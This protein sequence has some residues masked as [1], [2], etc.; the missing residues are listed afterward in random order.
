MPTIRIPKLLS[1]HAGGAH[2]IHLNATT[3]N[4]LLVELKR[5]HPALHEALVADNGALRPFITLIVDGEVIVDPLA[6][7]ELS[8][9]DT[10][11]VR[12]LSAIAGG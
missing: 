4:E 11:E 12:L 5:V 1:E 7:G 6:L 8:L 10:A 3:P 9:A 2:S